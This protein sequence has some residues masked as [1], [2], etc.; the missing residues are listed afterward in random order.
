MKNIVGDF[1]RAFIVGFVLPSVLMGITVYC[2]EQ[3]AAPLPEET[4][5]IVWEEPEIRYVMRQRD[6]ETVQERDLDAYLVGVVLAEMPASFER[7]ALKAQAVAARTYTRRAYIT[8]GKHGDGSVCV[9]STCCQAY[10]APEDYISQG[11]NLEDLEKVTSAVEATS[12]LVLTYEGALIEA[13]YFSSSGGRTEAAV[14]VWGA[15]Y[16]YLQSVISPGEEDSAYYRETVTFTPE[17]F[18]AR[19]GYTPEGDINAWCALTEYTHGGSVRQ[20]VIGETSFTGTEL[21]SL[22]GLRSAAFSVAVVDGQFE[23]TTK[24]YGHRVGMSQ[25]GAQAMAQSGASYADILTHYY[26][27]TELTWLGIESR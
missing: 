9:D 24:G 17:E 27:G 12:G 4:Q 16:P 25:Y 18:A 22:L 19:L 2:Y 7:E 21:R 8:G 23:I 11:G 1:I 15:E 3:K 10:I 26:S 13:T 14:E 5:P 20:M 6:G